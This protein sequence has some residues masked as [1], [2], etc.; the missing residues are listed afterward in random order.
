MDEPQ[1]RYHEYILRMIKEERKK[2]ASEKEVSEKDIY[3]HG[4]TTPGDREYDV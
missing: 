4:M 2:E 1:E 3:T